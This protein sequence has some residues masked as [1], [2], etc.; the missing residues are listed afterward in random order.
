MTVA[1]APRLPVISGKPEVKVSA[2][3]EL[4]PLNFMITPIDELKAIPVVSMTA[5]YHTAVAILEQ[6][7]AELTAAAIKAVVRVIFHSYSI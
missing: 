3:V 1:G 7:V 2:A 4:K 5:H 6:V